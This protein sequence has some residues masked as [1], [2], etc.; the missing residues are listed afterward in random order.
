[1][2]PILEKNLSIEERERY[3]LL[4]KEIAE[5]VASQSHEIDDLEQQ[6]CF[7]VDSSE[8]G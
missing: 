8:V 2:N 3:G 5:Q 1:M 6:L 4:P 7:M